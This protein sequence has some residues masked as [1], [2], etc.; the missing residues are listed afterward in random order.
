MSSIDKLISEINKLYYVGLTKMRIGNKS[1]GG[2]IVLE[3]L[4]RETSLLYTFGVGEDISFEL[5]FVNNFPKTN[6]YLFD[7]TIDNVPKEH[8]QLHFYKKDICEEYDKLRYIFMPYAPQKSLLKMDM[9]GNEWKAFSS[10]INEEKLNVF[11]QLIIEFHFIH[12]QSQIGLS[13]YFTK[14]YQDNFKGMNDELFAKYTRILKYLNKHFYIFHLHANNSLPLVE[15]AGHKLPPLLE[16]SFVSKTSVA[17]AELLKNVAFPVKG[18]DYPNKKD[19]P[20]IFNW[21]PVC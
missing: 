12:A 9:E 2:Y 11:S 7:P 14:M 6:C 10:M 20:D 3:E 21:F 13:P 17:N 1:D 16:V 19:R 18:L 15:I 4:C 8:P 5:A